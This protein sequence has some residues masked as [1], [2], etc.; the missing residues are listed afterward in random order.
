M[1][2]GNG[3]TISDESG[4]VLNITS[5]A[6]AQLELVEKMLDEV[7]GRLDYLDKQGLTD[8]E[9]LKSGIRTAKNYLYQA[10]KAL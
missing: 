9:Y 4:A 7:I 10:M 6:L 8:P 1:D 3:M 5:S 2:D